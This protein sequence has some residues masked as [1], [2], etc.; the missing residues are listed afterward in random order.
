MAAVILYGFIFL[1]GLAVGSFLN[2]V[3]C[4][5]ET[6]EDLVRKRSH[7][8]KCGQALRWFDLVPVVSFFFLR[9]RCRYCG[10]RIS[11]QYPAVELAAGFIFLAAAVLFFPNLTGNFLAADSG[12]FNL[13][14]V[15]SCLLWLFINCCLLVIFVYD[16]R[17]YIIPDSVL[18]PAVAA[19]GLYRLWEFFYPAS[20]RLLGIGELR[21]EAGPALFWPVLA[22]L[23]AATFFL[24]ITLVTRGRGMGLGDAKL[25]FLMGLVLGWPDILAAV[26]LAFLGGAAVGVALIA[27]GRKTMKSQIPF[28]PFLIAATLAAW[29]WG[30]AWQDFYGRWLFPW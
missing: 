28:G 10:Q 19:A 25:A 9:A 15:I 23:A 11:W 20:G 29:F 30:P 4:R 16:L 13:A 14:G 3:I 7:C 26:F 8:P 5:L 21:P 12:F 1:F 6:G 2:V 17:H 27:A 18:W 24:L 22:G